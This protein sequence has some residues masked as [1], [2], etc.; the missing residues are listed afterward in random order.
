[1]VVVLGDRLARPVL[2]DRADLELLVV[3]TELHR[4][5]LVVGWSAASADVAV[6]ISASAWR[7]LPATGTGQVTWYC[8]ASSLLRELK[9]RRPRVAAW[10]MS[11]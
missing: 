4:S 3:A 1:M 5:P 6:G 11:P 2:V 7:A 10:T 9:S 8:D